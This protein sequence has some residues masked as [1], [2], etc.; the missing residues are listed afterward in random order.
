[1]AV[2]RVRACTTSS[3]RAASNTRSASRRA[4]RSAVVASATREISN[5]GRRDTLTGF[6]AGVAAVT[7]SAVQP[8]VA[9]AAYGEAANVFGK[10]KKGTSFVPFAGDGYAVL[11][12]GKW[13]PSKEREFEGMD[14]RYEDNFDAVNNMYVLVNKTSA[15]STESLGDLDKALAGFSYLLGSQS[16]SGKTQSEGGF[17]ENRVSTAAVLDQSVE[18]IKG[19]KYYQW[20]I[21]TRTADGDEGGRH[22][23][24]KAVVS[25]GNLYVFKVQAGDKRWFKGAEKECR[26]S[27]TSFQVV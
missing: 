17:A 15:S 18:D 22:Q 10:E 16:F 2:I 14:M 24:I 9:K 21:L 26:E 11:V 1:M 6:M 12:P 7:V 5:N 23:L 25:N 13:N 19:K 27:F 20:E 8:D 3:R 4:L